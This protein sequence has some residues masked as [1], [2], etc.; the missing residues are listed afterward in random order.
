[1]KK[2]M[3]VSMLALSLLTACDESPARLQGARAAAQVCSAGAS[4]TPEKLL[5]TLA[6]IR[7]DFSREPFKTRTGTETA[8]GLYN[9]CA[10]QAHE[11]ILSAAPKD[12]KVLL[13]R[14]HAELVAARL[15][16]EGGG[17]LEWGLGHS[18]ISTD[19]VVNRIGLDMDAGMI[20]DAILDVASLTE[21]QLPFD[22]SSSVDCDNCFKADSAEEAM[23]AANSFKA[24]AIRSKVAIQK[25]RSTHPEIAEVLIGF[26]NAKISVLTGI[27]IKNDNWF[28]KTYSIPVEQ[29]L[30]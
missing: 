5:S 17:D 13:T 15:T 19:N 23:A 11:R 3:V 2:S 1:M 26:H 14:Y 27:S 4:A 25:I 16:H 20:E 6:K 8:Q 22:V 29:Y 9:A 30:L 18:I 28:G 7:R 10:T 21:L 24:A 12:Q